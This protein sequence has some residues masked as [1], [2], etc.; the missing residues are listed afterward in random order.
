MHWVILFQIFLK[1]SFLSYIITR[2]LAILLLLV[3]VLTAS[4]WTLRI[5]TGAVVA[6]TLQKVDCAPN[7]EA[8]AEDNHKGLE[9]AYSTFKEILNV[10]ASL[11]DFDMKNAA[12]YG[13][14]GASGQVGSKHK[15]IRL[16]LQTTNI[17]G[18][19]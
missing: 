8:S 6:V 12:H 9:N 17:K 4:I 11:N 7:G 5:G 14:N 16:F 15:L 13:G 10:T 2:L 19:L 1:T 18:I 3:V